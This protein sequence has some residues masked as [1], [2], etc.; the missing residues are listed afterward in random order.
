MTAVATPVTP[1]ATLDGFVA[2]PLTP[3]CAQV[4]DLARHVCL[5][6]SPFNG[7]YTQPRIDLLVRWG[8]ETYPSVSFYVPDLS[9][10]HTFRALGYAEGKARTKARRQGA[11]VLNKIRTA[12]GKAGVEDPE[13]YLQWSEP[14]AANEQYQ[15]LAREGRERFADDAA[16]RAATLDTSRWVL[17]GKIPDGGEPTAEQAELAVEYFLDELPFFVD[18]P[19]IV[20]EGPSVFVYHQPV[21]YLARL[22]RHELSL[23]P[24]EHQ[25]FLVLSTPEPQ[26]ED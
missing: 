9:P 17:A 13:P 11:Y 5:G 18:T 21:D 22:Y 6:I 12:L 3:R 2:T 20:G 19:A 15:R 1:A 16:F 14:L 10:Q 26:P 4:A 8:L 25:G 23:V 24:S 7:Y